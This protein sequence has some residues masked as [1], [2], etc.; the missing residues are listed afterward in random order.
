MLKKKNYEKFNG[1][2]TKMCKERKKEEKKAL[3]LKRTKYK[4]NGN[5]EQRI[6]YTGRMNARKGASNLFSLYFSFMVLICCLKVK[7]IKSIL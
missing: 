7:S 3:K 6:R 5:A 4:H 2:R 1:M